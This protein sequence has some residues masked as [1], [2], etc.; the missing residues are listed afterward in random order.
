MDLK[1][2]SKSTMTYQSSS[3]GIPLSQVTW[4]ARRLRTL[5][6][7]TRQ[8]VICWTNAGQQ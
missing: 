8:A 5:E 7:G 3:K 2:I 6:S 4:L 1:R